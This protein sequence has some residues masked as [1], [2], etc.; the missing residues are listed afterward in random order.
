VCSDFHN[1]GSSACKANSIKA[2]EAENEVIGKIESFLTD[3]NHFFTTIQSLNN[4][5]VQ[6][7]KQHEEE[8]EQKKKKLSVELSLSSAKVIQPELVQ[9]LLEK[10]IE[11]YKH[12]PRVKQKQLLQLLI[13]NISIE[14]STGRSRTVNKIELD[15]DFNETNISKTFT[16][17]HMLYLE[18][19]EEGVLLPIQTVSD[20]KIPP[21]LQ[22]FLPLFMVRFTPINLKRPVHLLNKNQPHKLV[23]ERHF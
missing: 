14:K 9:L 3:Q 2:Y 7:L 13:N 18:T 8:L 11:A 22:L 21:Y 16:L 5:S 12:S 15:F 10:F 6:S 19:D 23:W 1:K 20:N 4:H 17:I